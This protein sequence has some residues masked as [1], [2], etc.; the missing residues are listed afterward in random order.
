MKKHQFLAILGAAMIISGCAGND[1][2][3]SNIPDACPNN[4]E[5]LV[6]GVCGCDAPDVD[7]NGNGIMDCIEEVVDW[8]PD[9]PEKT[10]PGKC[11]CGIKDVDSDNDGVVDCLDGCPDDKNK[12]VPGYCGC[13][14]ADVDEDGNTIIDCIEKNADQCADVPGRLPDKMIPGICGCLAYDNIDSDGDT[15]P[16]CKDMCPYNAFKGEDEGLYGCECEDENDDDGDGEPNCKDECPDDSKK[17]VSGICGCGKDDNDEHNLADDDGDGVINCLDE[18]PDNPNKSTA[19]QLGC[20][21]NDLDGDGVEDSKD[22]C[23]TNPNI[24]SGEKGQ[25]CNYGPDDN[26]VKVFNVWN[27][28]DLDRLKTELAKNVT[29]KSNVH[30]LCKHDGS[31]TCESDKKANYCSSI[32]DGI[33]TWIDVNCKSC[34]DNVCQALDAVELYNSCNYNPDEVNNYSCD[35]STSYHC[36]SINGTI[37]YVDKKVTCTYNNNGS[38]ESGHCKAAGTPVQS[39]NSY[40]FA[41]KDY[42]SACDTVTLHGSLRTCV[43]G[44]IMP[45]KCLDSCTLSS[46]KESAHPICIEADPV[47]TPKLKVVLQNDIDMGDIVSDA[48]KEAT[49]YGEMWEPINLNQVEFEG[50][51]HT[52]TY[53]YNK[54]KCNMVEPLFGSVYNSKI[55]NLKLNYDFRGKSS[56]VLANLISRSIVDSVAYSGTVERDESHG[57]VASGIENP[58]FG[59]IAAFADKSKFSNISVSG[60]IYYSKGGASAMIGKGNNFHVA[61][62]QVKLDLFKCGGTASCFGVVGGIYTHS[63]L[64]SISVNVKDFQIENSGMAVG[65][66]QT[67]ADMY[68]INL[69]VDNL[70]ANGEW[71]SLFINHNDGSEKEIYNIFVNLK[72][73]NLLSKFNAAWRNGNSLKVSNAVFELDNVTVVNNGYVPIEQLTSSS[74]TDFVYYANVMLSEQGVLDT[75]L[76]Y[77]VENTALN[78]VV[79]NSR[80]SRAGKDTEVSDGVGI[81]KKSGTNT[82]TNVFYRADIEGIKGFEGDLVDNPIPFKVEETDDIVNKLN[83]GEGNPALWNAKVFK[84]ASSEVKLPWLGNK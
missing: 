67:A 41:C 13:N 27:A 36:K 54:N 2:I 31:L 46:V 38:C 75:R 30:F 62:S 49:C 84:E 17:K 23:P 26:G 29:P 25:E 55:K 12:T 10:E 64:D 52:I 42:T 71:S 57:T 68:N 80:I 78:R 19:G 9:D 56:S 5:K 83:D 37:G 50:N 66:A 34:T 33:S 15:I 3:T 65:I 22:P 51:N 44:V 82:G 39:G 16:D 45:K 40:G 21:A 81:A 18:C 24:S 47:E 60:K 77:T 11:G 73:V 20:D 74:L 8:C 59:V 7:A 35:A 53:H 6:P 70:N 58:N 79:N 69:N 48:K 43:D 14:E 1:P 28:K 61:N 72:K 4:P 76:I 32:V 63:V